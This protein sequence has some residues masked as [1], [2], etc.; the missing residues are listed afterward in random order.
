[1]LQIKIPQVLISQGCDKIINLLKLKI[2]SSLIPKLIPYNKLDIAF[3]S[4]Y[5]ILPK[6]LLLKHFIGANGVPQLNPGLKPAQ[7]IIPPLDPPHHTL[8]MHLG[9]LH[10]II[11]VNNALLNEPCILT[12][13]GLVVETKHVE[14][15]VVLGEGLVMGVRGDDGTDYGE[16]LVLF[17]EGLFVG[18]EQ[19]LGYLE[20]GEV[21]DAGS[22]VH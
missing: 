13:E 20:G 12:G 18:L 6:Y 10:P 1:M 4:L 11:V 14:L 3:L 15:C 17:G 8:L 2:T 9:I 7:Q 19:G 5:S 21:R 22:V 16:G